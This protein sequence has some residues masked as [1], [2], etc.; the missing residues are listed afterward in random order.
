LKKAGQQAA[1]SMS[2]VLILGESGTGKELLAQAIH[3]ASSRASGPFIAINCGSIPRNLIESELF[4]YEPGA[5]SGARREGN[6]G[7]F[8]LADGGTL[9][10]DEIGD[11]PLELQVTLLRVIQSREVTRLGGRFPKQVDVRIIAATNAD[12]LHAVEEK[13]FRGDLYYRLNVLTL[14]LPPLRDRKED[15]PFLCDYFLQRYSDSLGK[16]VTEISPET[17]ALLCQYSWPGNIRELENI[18][19]RAVNLAPARVITPDELPQVV[20]HSAGYPS[21][22]QP[23]PAAQPAPVLRPPKAQER[24]SI[25][26]YLQQEGGHVQKTAQAMDIPVSTLYRKLKKYG[27]DPSAFRP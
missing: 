4:G 18:I 7:K 8:E 15:I 20:L 25:L 19:E 2:N 13:M 21:R 22:V 1:L 24:E 5:F 16:M 10:L 9:F 11:M 14:T 3:N 12:L 23:V 17:M 27:I 26:A 6:P